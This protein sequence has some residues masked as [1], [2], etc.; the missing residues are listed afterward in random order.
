MPHY[1]MQPTSSIS[2]GC[3]VT[4]PDEGRGPWYSPRSEVTSGV[5]EPRSTHRTALRD[6]VVTG[7][8]DDVGLSQALPLTSTE[9]DTSMGWETEHA[10]EWRG[11]C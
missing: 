3:V 8:S 5:P 10:V 9:S 11:V 7:Y 2:P 4:L 1:N 6:T